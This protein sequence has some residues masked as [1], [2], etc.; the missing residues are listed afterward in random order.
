MTTTVKISAP[1]IQTGKKVVAAIASPESGAVYAGTTQELTSSDQE[2]CMH[3]H[4][5]GALVVKEVDVAVEGSPA[6]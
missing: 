5:Q 2:V 6:G 1:Y 4:D 3:I